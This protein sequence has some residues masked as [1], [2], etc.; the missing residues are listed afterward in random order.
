MRRRGYKIKIVSGFLIVTLACLTATAQDT[1]KKQT[2]TLRLG[3][4][5]IKIN[6]YESGKTP[7]TFFSPHHNEQIGLRIAR[8]LLPTRGGRLIEIE[9]I[10]AKGN[11]TRRV[12]FAFQGK[13]HSIDPNRIFTA[14]G[15]TCEEQSVAVREQIQKFADNLLKIILPPAGNLLPTGEKFLVAVHN[16]SDSDD[17]NRS[18]ESRANDLTAQSFVKNGR[19]LFS[20][21]NFHQQAAGAYLSNSESDNDNFFFLSSPEFLSFFAAR[22]FNV[23][24][25]KSAT[26]LQSS[27][28]DVD[29][30]SLSVFAGQQNISYINIEADTA[31][32]AARQRQMIEAV[33]EL[34]Q[35]TKKPL[36]DITGERREVETSK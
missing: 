7:L 3:E 1:I 12:Q 26:E 25:Q 36:S 28:C 16:N 13:N 27:N 33:Y 22:G 21:G 2:R 19:N 34:L 31:T 32:G 23:V 10:D 4:T 14:N 29:D 30:G 8:E 11:P 20:H 35:N 17:A 18:A 9:S 24:V 6:I 5:A 15:R